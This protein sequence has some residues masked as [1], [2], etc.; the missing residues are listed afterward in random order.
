MRLL[1]LSMLLTAGC[2]NPKVDAG[3]A[4]YVYHKPLVFGQMEYKETMLGPNSTGLSWRLFTV[5]VDVRETPFEEGFEPEKNNTV[6]TKDNLPVRLKV[7]TRIKVRTGKDKNGTDYLKTLV[8]DWGGPDW[9]EW[10][11]KQ[12][13][14]SIVRSVVMKYDVEKIQPSLDEIGAKIKEILDARYQGTPI[15]IRGVELAE[16]SMP[17]RVEEITE[18]IKT[19]RQVLEE[20]RSRLEVA[21]QN[22]KIAY[23]RAVNVS[24]QQRI[25]GK[26][27]DPLF[28]Q[29]EAIEVYRMLA[30][31]KSDTVIVL[32]SQS[33]GTALPQILPKGS[34]SSKKISEAE[35]AKLRALNKK[36]GVKE[37]SESMTKSLKVAPAVAP[38]PA[39]PAEESTATVPEKKTSVDAKS[40][41]PT[42]SN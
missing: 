33:E 41:S 12:P 8:E 40:A 13:L 31:S 35:K 34:A 38:E 29:R 24:D 32:P 28:V 22:A 25:I 20:Q 23:R 10:R 26:T 9:Y 5:D 37:F 7:R 14:R 1:I 11:V 42:S 17:K 6:L 2:S 39:Q 18:Q 16:F 19:E 30:A 36:Y 27:L 21:R 3:Y 15:E 4:S